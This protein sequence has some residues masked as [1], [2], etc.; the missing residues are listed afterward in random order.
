MGE[1]DEE[2][3]PREV[4]TYKHTCS[5]LTTDYDSS[6]VLLNDELITQTSTAGEMVQDGFE[7]ANC[8]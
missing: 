6:M 3:T 1:D 5:L 7:L 8:S 4:C 2:L